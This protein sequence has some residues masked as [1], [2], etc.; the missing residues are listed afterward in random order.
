MSDTLEVKEKDESSILTDS[1]Q[2]TYVTNS[3]LV[4]A[5]TQ[6][7][8]ELKEYKRSIVLI[9]FDFAEI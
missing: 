2:V 4:I 7:E 5:T 1:L 8:D 9:K 3:H 6:N